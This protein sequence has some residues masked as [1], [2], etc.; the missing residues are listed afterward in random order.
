MLYITVRKS[1]YGFHLR[2]TMANDMSEQ[3][4]GKLS[5]IAERCDLMPDYTAHGFQISSSVDRANLE[6]F[7]LLAQLELIHV[8]MEDFDCVHV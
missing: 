3:A 6:D 2:P 1:E 8:T 4:V 5:S 7:C